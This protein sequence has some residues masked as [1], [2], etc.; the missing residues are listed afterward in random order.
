M[1]AVEIDQPY[2][3]VV[4][5]AGGYP[6]DIDLRQAHKGLENACRAL[7]PGG[8]I[9]F[10]AECPNGAGIQ[11]FEDYVRRYRDEFEMRAAL[12]HEFAVGGHKAYWV[13]RLGRLYDIHLVSALDP[14]FVRRCHFQPVALAEHAAALQRLLEKAGPDARVAVIPHSGF[15]LPIAQKLMEVPSR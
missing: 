8:S 15:T 6:L 3:V 2:D 11:S 12:E 1:L 14:E 7:R 9:L 4:A 10:Y 13:A 5:S